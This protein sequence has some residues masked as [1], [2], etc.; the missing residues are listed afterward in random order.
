MMHVFAPGPEFVPVATAEFEREVDEFSFV[1]LH[2]V[3][4]SV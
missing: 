1:G 3:G 2:R 4:L